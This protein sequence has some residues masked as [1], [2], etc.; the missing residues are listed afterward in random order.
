MKTMVQN[1]SADVFIAY[2][3][4]DGVKLAT[5]VRH[6]LVSEGLSV[7]HDVIASDDGADWWSHVEEALTSPALQHVVLILTPGGFVSSNVRNGVRL[8]RQQGKAVCSVKGVS[9]FNPEKM[10]R[11]VGDMF[12]PNVAEQRQALLNL[13]RQPRPRPRVP[14][15][16][17]PKAVAIEPALVP[18][19]GRGHNTVEALCVLP[20]GHLASSGW[21]DFICLWDATTGSVTAHLERPPTFFEFGAALCALPDGRLAS[22]N[23]RWIQL[24]DIASGAKAERL[25]GLPRTT[26]GSLHDSGWASGIRR[27]RQRDPSLGR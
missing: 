24:W 11:W 16:V 22:A 3:R 5:D 9:Y 1:R 26:N 8:A 25:E 18:E 7:W 4:E 10:P 14:R 12:D 27:G 6:W 2:S 15:A 23:G 17:S 13:L 19:N 20:D 21:D